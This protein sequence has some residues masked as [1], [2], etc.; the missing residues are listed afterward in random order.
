MP[1]IINPTYNE[2][3][4]ALLNSQQEPRDEI[5]TALFAVLEFAQK[6][7]PGMLKAQ[8]LRLFEEALALLPNDQFRED[9]D[10]KPPCF[11]ISHSPSDVLCVGGVDVVT[12]R[13]EKGSP[14]RPQC[15]FFSDCGAAFR[16]R[17]KPIL[18]PISVK[19]DRTERKRHKE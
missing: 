9:A 18:V 3:Q 8:L 16:G 12:Y 4:A 2:V 13:D 7:G 17:P 14:M 11:A 19:K 5:I 6:E 15:L 10:D 1:T